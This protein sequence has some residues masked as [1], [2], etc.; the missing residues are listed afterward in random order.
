VARWLQ[1]SLP[2][3]LCEL[4]EHTL[5]P[6]P[7]DCLSMRDEK[8]VVL[9]LPPRMHAYQSPRR[10]VTGCPPTF[11]CV[12]HSLSPPPRT[13]HHHHNNNN[14]NN[15][16]RYMYFSCFFS[17]CKPWEE[18]HQVQARKLHVDCKRAM[19]SCVS[20][21]VRKPSSTRPRLAARAR[22]PLC[23]MFRRM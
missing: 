12:A 8:M 17:N 10:C 1:V 7:T 3:R 5:D 21:R 15:N 18:M 11:Y 22:T 13:M 4:G 9:Q 23:A 19:H 14:N 16:R 2:E 20:R 6:R